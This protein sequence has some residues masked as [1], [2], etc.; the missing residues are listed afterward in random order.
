[1]YVYSGA[2]SMSS[3]LSYVIVNA[4]C[5]CLQHILVSDC[6]DPLESNEIPK[7]MTSRKYM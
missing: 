1:M 4:I 2:K 7:V 5:F 6:K 3:I